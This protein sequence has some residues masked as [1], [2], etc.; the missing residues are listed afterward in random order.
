MQSSCRPRPPKHFCN[1]SHLSRAFPCFH[2]MSWSRSTSSSSASCPNFPAAWKHRPHMICI[3]PALLF[4]QWQF[5]FSIRMEMT[6]AVLASSGPPA[7]WRCPAI[8]SNAAASTTP[9]MDQSPE[10]SLL[11]KCGNGCC[12]LG[13][14]TKSQC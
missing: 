6:L 13:P 11:N 3:S 4:L 2:T 14:C 7:T 1:S 10:S 12:P 8:A 9:A 5:C